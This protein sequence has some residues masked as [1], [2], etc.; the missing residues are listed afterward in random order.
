VNVL[1]RFPGRI[2]SFVPGAVILLAVFLAYLPALSG[3]FVWDDDSWT[4]GLQPL[5]QSAS[6]L[7]SMWSQPDALQQY[8]PL[9]GT[10]FWLDYQLWKFWPAPYHVENILLHALAAV[11]FW[12]LLRRL[13]L[14]GAWLAA[15][16]FAL[17]PVMVESAAWITE[18]KNVLS[19]FPFLA[20]LL[21]YERFAPLSGA[22][23]ETRPP[24]PRARTALLYGLALLLFLAAM[25]AKTTTFSLPAVVLLLVWW[26]RG[27]L[28]WRDVL[29]TLPFFILAAG[30]C[31]VTAWLEKN[32][33]NAQG[34]DFAL[35]FA[36]R[37]LV[38]GH[39]FWFY[40]AQLLWPAN[41]CFVYPR[42]QPD[43][44][45]WWQWL[46]P[47]CA[48]GGLLALWLARKRTGRGPAAAVFF[49]A[50]TLFPVMGFMNAY[51]MRY[52]YVWDHWVYLSSL[53]W[54]ALAAALVAWAADRWRTPALATGFAVVILPVLGLLTWQRTQ[55]YRD[56]ETLWHDTIARNP[57]CWM[58]YN[59]L[60][61]LLAHQR[62][63]DEAMACYRKAVRLKPD[64]Y[65]VLNNLGDTLA[66]QGRPDEAIASY[67]RALQINPVY[68]NA[69]SGLGAADSA[70]GRYYEAVDQYRLAMSIQPDAPGLLNNLAWIFATCP[71]GQ[72]R[73]GA[74]AVRLAE[75]ACELDHDQNPLFIGTLAAA[76]AEAG[77][78]ADA[79]ATAQKAEQLAA[80]AGLTAVVE[81]NRQL[82]ELYQEGKPY[83]DAPARP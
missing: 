32:H 77:R 69:L 82:L 40:P 10:T 4:T 29:P 41:L 13:Q 14:P 2:R 48:V 75:R 19:Q 79:V 1:E 5:F 16:L 66:T 53:G 78:F 21:A 46:Y 11:L 28:G 24:R 31:A 64:S 35:S 43:P 45:V 12:R 49:Y 36:Q 6:G 63:Y 61:V 37:C 15:M 44:Q 65:E 51:G 62:H 27:R 80:D 83:R 56:M 70:K 55:V 3:G 57:D 72:L 22:A 38:A 76:Y 47:L 17:H 30:F 73:D 42:W 52:A 26:K 67:Q 68:F 9:T 25:L 54:L 74:E 60:G 71:D 20:A 23:A 18:R 81:K 58:A 8:Y 50:G 59:N 33:V 34:P 7:F 39:V